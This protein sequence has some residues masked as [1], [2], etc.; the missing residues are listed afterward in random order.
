MGKYH[1][2]KS[3]YEGTGDQTGIIYRKP[4][5]YKRCYWGRIVFAVPPIHCTPAMYEKAEYGLAKYKKDVGFMAQGW[6]TAKSG[7]YKYWNLW[8]CLAMGRITHK[9]MIRVERGKPYIC[10]YTKKR[11]FAY[12][13][14]DQD[15]EKF[16]QAIASWKA[17]SPEEKTLW[18]RKASSF[19]KRLTGH[20]LYV[21]KFIRGEL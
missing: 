7:T 14:H 4:A 1:A 2:A 21:R 18:N 17:L 6:D 20:N 10:K 19:Y 3:A 16:R 13:K 5:L 9:H 12:E 11:E 15:K 8:S